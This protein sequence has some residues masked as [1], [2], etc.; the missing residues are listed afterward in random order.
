MDTKNQTPKHFKVE[1]CMFFMTLVED[2]Q[3]KELDFE[4][5]RDPLIYNEILLLRQVISV[6]INEMGIVNSAY[7]KN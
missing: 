3:R 2:R 6:M 7:S 4:R 5:T 1:S